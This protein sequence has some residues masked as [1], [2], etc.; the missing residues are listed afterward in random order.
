MTTIFH[1]DHPTA[2]TMNDMRGLLKLYTAKNIA[3][4]YDAAVDKY[5]GV[6]K[7]LMSEILAKKEAA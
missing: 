3:G 2:T 7:S 1:L 4:K 5:S 6:Y